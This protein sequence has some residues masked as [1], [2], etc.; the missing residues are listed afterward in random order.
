MY[1]LT[2]L[3]MI[4]KAK[5]IYKKFNVMEDIKKK[6]H[7]DEFNKGK[8]DIGKSPRKFIPVPK[9][10]GNKFVK[11]SECGRV[12][13]SSKEGNKTSSCNICDECF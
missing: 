12:F 5:F 11:C 10:N 3:I 13:D 6:A 2:F 8:E 4:S 9:V 7:D 1:G